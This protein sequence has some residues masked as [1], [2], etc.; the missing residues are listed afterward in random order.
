MH[1]PSLAALIAD[2]KRALSKGPVALVLLEDAIE[3]DSTLT[4]LHNLGFANI[5]AFGAAEL[6]VPAEVDRVDHDVQSDAALPQI[7]NAVAQAAP[8]I[9][10]HYCYNAEYLFYPFCETRS[11]GELTGFTTEE[12]RNSILTYV[13]DLYARDL[14]TAPLGVDRQ[15]ACL[16]RAGYYALARTDETGEPLDRQIDFFGGLRWRFEEH[17]PYL[18]RRIDRISIF[19]AVP[20]LQMLSDRRFNIPEFN[21]Y[22]CP[23]HHNI[24]ATVCS[25]RTAKA[26]KRNPSSRN[27][28]G[29]F[30]WQNSEPFNWHS[31]QLC[32]LG[33]MEPGQWF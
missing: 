32:D 11:V 4:H 33:L 23:W 20:G 24:T 10:L 9:W 17:V 14:E 13:V 1:Y 8:D 19:Q 5:I 12:R 7:V 29:D 3:V 6:D 28:I 31:Q 30:H 15:S 25:F 21:T 16:D 27:K 2:R 22:A 26:L 18:R